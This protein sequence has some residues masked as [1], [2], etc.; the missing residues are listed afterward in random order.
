MYLSF[1][2]THRVLPSLPEYALQKLSLT[3]NHQPSAAMNTGVI[4][5]VKPMQEFPIGR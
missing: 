1:K 3:A 5:L 2:H 4:T